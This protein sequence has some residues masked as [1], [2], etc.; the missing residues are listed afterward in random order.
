[1]FARTGDE[2]MKTYH[3]RYC[4]T[5]G[6]LLRI[7]SAVQRRSIDLSFIHAEQAGELHL[8][9][10]T[11]PQM[12]AKQAGQLCRDWRAIV[13]VLEVSTADSATTVS[14]SVVNAAAHSPASRAVPRLAAAAVASA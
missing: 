14:A 8:L 4:N 12:N 13:D 3:I 2:T 1:M 9:T 5:Q 7:L 10:L 11:L 6:T